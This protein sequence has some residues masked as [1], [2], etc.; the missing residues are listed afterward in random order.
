MMK[1]ILVLPGDTPPTIDWQTVEGAFVQKSYDELSAEFC[2]AMQYSR[3]EIK[4]VVFERSVPLSAFVDFLA[5]PKKDFRGDVLFIGETDIFLSA[6]LAVEG[7][8]MYRL[9]AE[10]LQFYFFVQLRSEEELSGQQEM[11]IVA[12]EGAA[13]YFGSSPF[14]NF[15]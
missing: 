1:R 3:A 7:R 10:D 8:V 2:F 12:G 15:E 6:M 14:L 13:A 9:S 5:R 4:L 11:P